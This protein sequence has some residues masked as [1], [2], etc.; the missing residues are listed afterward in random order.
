VNSR[1]VAFSH[2][3]VPLQPPRRRRCAQLSRSLPR[4]V[5]AKAVGQIG[6]RAQALGASR[7]GNRLLPHAHAVVLFRSMTDIDRT[8]VTFEQAEGLEPLPSQLKPKELTKGLRA[9][10]WYVLHA[11]LEEATET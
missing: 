2:H 9:G 4:Q 1:V 7:I 3:R 5:L 10:L 11:H 6:L 8:N